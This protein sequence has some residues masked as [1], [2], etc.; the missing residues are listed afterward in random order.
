MFV[1]IYTRDERST[2][3][4]LTDAHDNIETMPPNG[5]SMT[6]RTQFRR[7]GH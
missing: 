2:I 7:Y 3:L 4:I 5:D 6:Q 1:D